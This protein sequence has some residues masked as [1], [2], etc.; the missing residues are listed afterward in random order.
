MNLKKLFFTFIILFGLST[1]AQ[2][3]FKLGVKAGVNYSGF[4]VNGAS[5]YT[6]GFGFLGGLIGEYELSGKISLQPELIFSQ[7]T[8]ARGIPGIPA[9]IRSDLSY[10]DIPLNGKYYIF[11]GFAVEFGPQFDFLINDETT[12]EFYTSNHNEY[13]TDLETKP[14]QISLNI[15]LSYKIVDKYLLQFRYS[16]GLSNIFENIDAK[17]SVFAFSLGYYFL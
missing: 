11:D 6:N 1:N 9:G 8:G 5:S 10:I 4:N 3:E 16:H 14:I 15:G 17:N 13:P 12:T 2:N 7:K